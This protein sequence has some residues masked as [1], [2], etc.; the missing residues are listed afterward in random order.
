[1]KLGALMLVIMHHA[2]GTAL[3]NGKLKPIALQFLI[4]YGCFS[5]MLEIFRF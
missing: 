4:Q 2:L 1:M 5:S 3:L